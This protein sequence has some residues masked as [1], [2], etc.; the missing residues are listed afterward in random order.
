[1][2]IIE[3]LCMQPNVF[4]HVLLVLYFCFSLCRKSQEP[5]P[6]VNQVIPIMENF[7]LI[8]IGYFY[9]NLIF[10]KFISDHISNLILF[11]IPF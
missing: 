5:Y 10:C 7:K 8:I 3:S 4:M 6:N 9:V 1:M 11:S 2:L